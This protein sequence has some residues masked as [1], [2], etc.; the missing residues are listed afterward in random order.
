MK[1]NEKRQGIFFT[2]GIRKMEIG[3]GEMRWKWEREI[4]SY[5]FGE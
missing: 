1:G 5:L 2:Y 3:Q 4:P